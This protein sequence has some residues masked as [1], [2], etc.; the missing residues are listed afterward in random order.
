MPSRRIKS[1]IRQSL[2]RL[3]TELQRELNDALWEA[4]KR[5]Q[6]DF[7]NVVSNWRN[8]PSFT[9]TTEVGSKLL[10]VKV[11]PQRN[12]A[13]MIWTWLDQGTGRY[14][15]RKAAYPIRP[16]PPNTRLAFRT[17]YSPKTAV[18]AR[19]LAGFGG[20]GRATGP[21][22]RP[23]EVMHPGIKPRKFSIT[24]AAKLKPPLKARIENAM[25]RAIRRAAN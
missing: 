25:R 7:K 24:F 17:G 14:G 13:G 2:I 16:I 4:G 20:L 1:S 9:V 10:I 23:K 6:S 19:G 22:V 11:V 21:L 18:G 15:K 3:D 5:L 8:K 12:R